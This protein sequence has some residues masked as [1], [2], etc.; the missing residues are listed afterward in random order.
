MNEIKVFNFEQQQVRTTMI[1]NNPYWVLK[2]VCEVLEIKN[3]RDVVERLDEDEVDLTDIIDSVGRKQKTTIINESGLY[4]VILRSDKPNAKKFRKWV[5][6]E[7]LPT[8]RKTGAYGVPT[9]FKEALLLA[10]KQQE[11]IEK[12]QE[13]II[14]QNQQIG[15]LKPKADYLDKIL[16]SKSLMTVT[17]IAKD[18]GMSAAQLNKTLK[19]LGIQY[20]QGDQWFLYSKYH[21]NGYTQSETVSIVRTNGNEDTV[22]NTKWTQ[23]GRLFLYNIL[24]TNEVLPSIEREYN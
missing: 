3:N 4:S 24:K 19:K 10:V 18:Y 2:D 5:T 20:K 13:T 21:A 16:K 6:S 22:L 8:I 12:Q 7:V 15:E 14:M 23:K 17:A 1:N 9:N 11:Q